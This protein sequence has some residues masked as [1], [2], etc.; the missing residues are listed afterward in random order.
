MMDIVYFELNN[1]FSGRDYPDAE[2][3]ISWMRD[4]LHQRFWD[5]SWVKANRL[6][7][8]AG[9]YDMSQNFLITAPKSWVEEHCPE[10]LT[11]YR[12]FLRF[13]DPKSDG[14]VYGRFARPFLEYEEENIGITEYED[15]YWDEP[16]ESEDDDE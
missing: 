3:F 11:K 4:D 9:F 2:P 7:V 1:W 15:N 5:E 6:C 16:I 12:E 13:P 8:A 14:E 10:L